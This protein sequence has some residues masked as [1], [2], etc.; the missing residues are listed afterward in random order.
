MSITNSGYDDPLTVLVPRVVGM[1]LSPP[2]LEFAHPRCENDN[3]IKFKTEIPP[4]ESFLSC[5]RPS[6]TFSDRDS[7][8]SPWENN[9]NISCNNFNEYSENYNFF[10]NTGEMRPMNF[11]SPQHNVQN[12]VVQSPTNMSVHSPQNIG[13]NMVQ[14]P[15]IMGGQQSMDYSQFMSQFPSGTGWNIDQNIGNTE[16]YNN[17]GNF[18]WEFLM[19]T[20]G[21]LVFDFYLIIVSFRV[22]RVH[23]F[24]LK[25]S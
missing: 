18:D 1:K 3:H 7:K 25:L 16:H 5:S 15:T 12:N 23:N 24:I 13:Q 21:E 14:S 10:K 19:G 20:L 8:K 4:V 2:E 22:N 17:F 6:E 9:A 11:H